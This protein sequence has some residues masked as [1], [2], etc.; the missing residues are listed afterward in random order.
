MTLQSVK[1]LSVSEITSSIKDL[2]EGKFRFVTVRGEISNLK[3]PYSGHSY[4]TLKDSTAQIRAVLF[5]NQKRF[6]L[7]ELENGA[8]I[9]CHGRITLYE[10]R[11]EY[12]LLIDS[13]ENGG[14]GALQLQFEKTKLELQEKGYFDPSRKKPLPYFPKKIV[15]ISSAT[16]AALKDFLKVVERRAS[17]CHFLIMPVRVQGKLAASEIAK[18]IAKANKIGDIEAIVV[19]RG[20]G[21][22]EDLWAFN[23]RIVADAIFASDVP[24]ISGVGHEIDFTISDFCADLRAATPTAAAEQL[25]PDTQILIEKIAYHQGRQQYCIEQILVD[26]T[27]RVK[28]ASKGLRKTEDI[29]ERSLLHLEL[30]SSYLKQAMTSLLKKEQYRLSTLKTKL[31]AEAPRAK[32]TLQKEKVENLGLRL[33]KAI[34]HNVSEKEASFGKQAA[35]LH[36]VSPLATLSRG[37]S[38]TRSYTNNEIGTVISTT[39]NVEIHDKVHILLHDG[40]LHCEVLDK[41]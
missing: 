28:R 39:N 37:Y 16:G 20:G 5:K 34:N 38:V 19:C 8:D 24:I 15:I 23:E 9:I 30:T 33:L 25:L 14:Q 31:H 2:I 1:I 18:A 6:L 32:I 7:T 12:Q 27:I 4:F 10:P 22:I 13:I 40:A 11:G 21:S 17:N 36:S 41:E 26:K 3:T 29:I 35:L